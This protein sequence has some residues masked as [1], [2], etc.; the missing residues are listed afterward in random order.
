MLFCGER[1]ERKAGRELW[2]GTDPAHGFS[3]DHPMY[4]QKQSKLWGHKAHC[5]CMTAD[6]GVR[7]PP[8]SRGA[9][10]CRQALTDGCDAP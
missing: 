3:W 7:S 1:F 9:S 2:H 10:R 8:E 5:L 4:P 6:R